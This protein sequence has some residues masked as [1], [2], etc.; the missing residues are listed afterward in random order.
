MGEHCCIMSRIERPR[1]RKERK[2]EKKRIPHG[3]ILQVLP[4]GSV[5]VLGALTKYRINLN[6]KTLCKIILQV[7]PDGSVLRASQP[8]RTCN[9]M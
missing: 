2:K 8:G 7:L 4:D 9:I 1:E 5:G 6:L 3:I